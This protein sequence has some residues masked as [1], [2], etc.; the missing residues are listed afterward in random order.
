MR[1]L[2]GI[3]LASLLAA[4]LG[5]HAETITL[6]LSGPMS[7]AGASWGLLAEWVAKQAAADINKSGGVK[8]DGKAYTFDVVAYDNKYTVSEGAKAGQARVN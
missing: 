1:I 5:A 8:I 2:H 4:P 7:G 6:G 3:L